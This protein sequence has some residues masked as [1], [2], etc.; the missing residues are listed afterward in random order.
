M[1]KTEK[2]YA[3][4]LFVNAPREGAPDFVMGSL[5]ITKDFVNFVKENEQYF[6]DKGY[7]RLNLL[8][9]DKSP[10]ATVDTYGLNNTQKEQEPLGVQS[11]DDLPF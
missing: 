4:G 5:S 8:I 2:I 3:K 1:S 7:L 9:G 10:Y 6:N 11:G